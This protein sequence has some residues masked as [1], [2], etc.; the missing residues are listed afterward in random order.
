MKLME[1]KMVLRVG[2]LLLCKLRIL[3]NTNQLYHVCVS[4]AQRQLQ[5]ISH[6]YMINN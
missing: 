1:T 5:Y 3:I 6:K 4:R 2:T